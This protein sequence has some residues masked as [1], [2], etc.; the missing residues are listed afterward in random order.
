MR[1][2]QAADG[3]GYAR[4]LEHAQD[5]QA[6]LLEQLGAQL[7]DEPI[8]PTQTLAIQA[9]ALQLAWQVH[10]EQ[11]VEPAWLR[12][13]KAE[14]LRGILREEA[15]RAP[16]HAAA[17][18][19]ADALAQTLTA[20]GRHRVVVHGD[21]HVGNLLRRGEHE[22]AFIDPDGFECD[23]SYDLGVTLRHF[24]GELAAVA[25]QRG[26]CGVHAQLRDWAQ[27]LAERTGVD[28]ELIFD[29]ALVERV[30]TG[31]YLLR[32]GQLD[33]GRSLL[34]LADLVVQGD[35]GPALSSATAPSHAALGALN[36]CS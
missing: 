33:E 26:P 29:W 36:R 32:F 18:A 11:P 2:L 8:T 10:L 4:V 35:R 28:A 21:P 15:H 23:A 12:W 14:G 5:Q 17:V 13:D 31:L 1:T 19:R 7:A 3:H 6:V 24:S 27:F 22:W 20:R 25:E 30:T 16:E 34:A 9:D